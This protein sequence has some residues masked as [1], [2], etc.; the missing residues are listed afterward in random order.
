LNYDES[1][2]LESA[3]W[4]ALGMGICILVLLGIVIGGAWLI[5]RLIS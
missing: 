5:F 4:A 3:M 1:W 2:H